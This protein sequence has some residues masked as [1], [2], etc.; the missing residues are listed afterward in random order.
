MIRVIKGKEHEEYIKFICE[1]MFIK[2]SPNNIEFY[3]DKNLDNSY[4]DFNNDPVKIYIRED[5]TIK[6]TIIYMLQKY[7]FICVMDKENKNQIL[8]ELMS[9]YLANYYSITLFDVF[10]SVDNSNLKNKLDSLKEDMIEICCE[11]FKETLNDLDEG[12]D[13]HE[14]IIMIAK[15]LACRNILKKYNY[16]HAIAHEACL[17]GDIMKDL[18]WYNVNEMYSKIEQVYN[19][20]EGEKNKYEY[21]Y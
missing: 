5:N 2:E 17:L 15:I 9:C 11:S 20:Y 1:L 10:D 4:I 12:E 18:D 7:R 16:N 14:S 13:I 21:R 3:I 6:T 19:S 8:L